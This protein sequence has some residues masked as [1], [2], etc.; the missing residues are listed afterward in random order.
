M[1]KNETKHSLE[2]AKKIIPRGGKAQQK[3]IA[4]ALRKLQIH[5]L[6]ELKLEIKK[7]NEQIK[8]LKEEVRVIKWH[9]YE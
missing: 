7:L 9:P 4:L 8:E 2:V 5:Q 1:K 6:K 3:R